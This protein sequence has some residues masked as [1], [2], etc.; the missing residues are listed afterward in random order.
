[1][2]G[3]RLIAVAAKACP[4]NAEA[5]RSAPCLA[6]EIAARCVY[7]VGATCMQ[8]PYSTPRM[9]WTITSCFLWALVQMR[10]GNM[11]SLTSR[12]GDAL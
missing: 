9:F 10:V 5:L 1:M 2:Y 6:Q 7:E 11:I 12:G 4:E 8:C 3:M